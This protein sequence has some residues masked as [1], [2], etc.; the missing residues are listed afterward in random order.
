MKEKLQFSLC[1]LKHQIMNWYGEWSLKV[2]AVL[3]S[4]LDGV[5][6]QLHNPTALHPGTVSVV[7]IWQEAGRTP[8]PVLTVLRRDKSLIL[9]EINHFSPVVTIET[10]LYQH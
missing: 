3:N 7:H 5:E 10:G 8:E 2:H 9:P 1:L 4:E 6:C